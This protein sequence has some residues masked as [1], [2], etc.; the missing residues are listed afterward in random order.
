MQDVDGKSHPEPIEALAA[1]ET[2]RRIRATS[3]SVCDTTGHFKG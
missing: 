2:L 1:D 3:L